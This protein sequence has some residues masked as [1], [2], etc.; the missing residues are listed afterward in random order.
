MKKLEAQID[1]LQEFYQ[2]GDLSK[3]QVSKSGIYWH[4]DHCLRILEAVPQALASSTAVD[5]KPKN[6]FTKF[7]IM[8]TGWIPRGKGR[9]PKYV[10]P[11][12]GN[13]PETVIEQRF[14]NARQ[15][16]NTL[17]DLEAD[18]HFYHPLFGSL[19]KKKAIKFLGIHTHHHL[20]I[21]RDMVA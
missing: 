19:T 17:K 4:V 10:T 13:I 2:M 6:S 14:E 11:K 18:K 21:L 1:E 9:A 7:L 15:Q 16:V 20:K 3:A 5:Y 12:K 8:T